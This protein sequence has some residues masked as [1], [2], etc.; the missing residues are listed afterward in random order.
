MAKKKF[1]EQNGSVYRGGELC[2]TI[3]RIDSYSYDEDSN[4]YHYILSFRDAIR[5]KNIQLSI[6]RDELS[7]KKLHDLMMSNGGL[8]NDPKAMLEYFTQKECVV[9]GVGDKNLDFLGDNRYNLDGS[10]VPKGLPMSPVVRSTYKEVGWRDTEEGI[11]FYGAEKYTLSGIQNDSKYIGTLKIYP[12]GSFDVYHKL[13]EDY[14]VNNI[15]LESIVAI[16]ASATVLGFANKVWGENLNNPM[17]HIYG[18]STTG[19]TTAAMLYASFGGCPAKG[20]GQ[21]VYLTFGGTLNALVKKLGN[22][23]GYPVAIDELSHMLDKNLTAFIHGL[24]GGNEKE[25]L[26]GGGEKVQEFATCV[27][28]ILTNGEGSILAKCDGSEGLRARVFEFEGVKWTPSAAV[29]DE[30]KTVV[31]YNYGF[32]TPLIAQEL[33]SDKDDKWHSIMK[34]WQDKFMLKANADKVCTGITDRV[35]KILALF[36]TSAEI[37]SKVL[38]VDLSIDKIFDFYYEQI[39]VKYAD[40][41]NIGARVY[42]YVKNYYAKNKDQFAYR[43][44]LWNGDDPSSAT[45]KGTVQTI[46]SP[47][48]IAGVNYDRALCIVKEDAK[49]I[50]QKGGF[51]DI[52]VCMRSLKDMGLLMTKDNKR[53]EAE[54]TLNNNKCTGYKILLPEESY[55]LMGDEETEVI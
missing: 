35:A 8:N 39:I 30:I 49:M 38:K 17:V 25:R 33:L 6:Y 36:M 31:T 41:G 5:G 22:N 16:S 51:S 55:S 27:T 14:V 1:T 34:E 52:K 29:A 32:V 48:N 24:A 44:S 9:L 26:A 3:I 23:A 45:V 13:I 4:K 47:K 42:D 43:D 28:T 12:T 19:K 54:F 18:N 21:S 11:A 37:V 10:L 15:Y 2:G 53:L 40:E 7:A 20:K 50:M 46:K